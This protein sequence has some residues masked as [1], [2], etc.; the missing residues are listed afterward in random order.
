M[1]NAS[2][3]VKAMEVMKCAR[4]FP[5]FETAPPNSPANLFVAG[6]FGSCPEIPMIRPLSLPEQI[7]FP[8]PDPA[9]CPSHAP[10]D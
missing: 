5:L 3:R 2:S 6:L 7:D 4:G 9:R 10:P 1:R 8:E